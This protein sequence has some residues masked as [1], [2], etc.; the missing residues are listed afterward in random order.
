MDGFRSQNCHND[1]NF[2]HYRLTCLVDNMVGEC[3]WQKEGKV[4]TTIIVI[5]VV[6]ISIS[7]IIIIII[8]V[9]IRLFSLSLLLSL[10]S[11][12]TTSKLKTPLPA[13]DEFVLITFSSPLSHL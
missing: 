8:V 6:G 11:S 3:R 5:V 4:N 10:C 7:I 13:A 1:N 12:E 2:F 9:A